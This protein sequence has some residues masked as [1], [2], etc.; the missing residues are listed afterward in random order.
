MS[1]G[2][3]QKNIIEKKTL[4]LFTPKAFYTLKSSTTEVTETNTNGKQ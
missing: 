3:V 4:L 1:Q 2:E